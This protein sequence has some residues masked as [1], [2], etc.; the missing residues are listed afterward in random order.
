[1]KLIAYDKVVTMVMEFLFMHY[2]KNAR[3]IF[4]SVHFVFIASFLYTSKEMKIR[5]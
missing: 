4:F 5:G 1:M 2:Q 3:L